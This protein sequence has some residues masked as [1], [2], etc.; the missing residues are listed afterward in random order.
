MVTW[1]LNGPW[2]Q[3]RI[4]PAPSGSVPA[5]GRSGAGRI[6]AYPSLD[7]AL[8]PAEIGI[9]VAFIALG[10]APFAGRSARMGVPRG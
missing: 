8:G 3:A 5:G 2:P 7:M 10:A 6:E 9:A 1:P 4:S